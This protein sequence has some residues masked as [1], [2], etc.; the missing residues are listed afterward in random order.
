VPLIAHSPLLD[1]GIQSAYATPVIGDQELHR[2]IALPARR[3]TAVR[4]LRAMSIAMALRPHGATAPALL[5]R[6][7]RPLLLIWGRRDQ[8]VPLRVAEQ[9][10]GVRTD[11]PLEVVEH[12][13]HC[14]HDEHPA[15]FNALLL[16]W[17][18]QFSRA[19]A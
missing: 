13:G 5:A 9:A 11:L 6:L 8:L 2:V 19:D 17:L 3:P 10:R 18:R 1:L 14:P 12:C 15:D 16:D 7:K 4:S